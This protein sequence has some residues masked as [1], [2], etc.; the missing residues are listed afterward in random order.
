[1]NPHAF[2]TDLETD[3]PGM[4]FRDY[5]AVHADVAGFDFG[6]MERLAEFVGQEP[7]LD[8]E[9]NIEAAIRM[10]MAAQAKLKY[11]LADAM[12]LEREKDKSW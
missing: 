1:M 9:E 6:N 2:P 10:S 4:S 3:V 5:A 7:I 11:M 12:R 8:P